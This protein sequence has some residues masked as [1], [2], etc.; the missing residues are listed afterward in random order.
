MGVQ[1]VLN[2]VMAYATALTMPSSPRA[3]EEKN[4]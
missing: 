4:Y 2:R 3:E 1:V